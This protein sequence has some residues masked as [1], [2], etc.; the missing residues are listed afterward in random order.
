MSN[1]VCDLDLSRLVWPIDN[2]QEHTASGSSIDLT[3]ANTRCSGHPTGHSFLD[4]VFDRLF[5]ETSKNDVLASSKVL[6]SSSHLRPESTEP[7]SHRHE[8]QASS[9]SRRP[10][11]S[12]LTCQPKA[13]IPSSWSTSYILIR[14]NRESQF[15]SENPEL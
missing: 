14:I 2:D 8:S 11:N 12:F 10:F 5:G 13:L 15:P 4:S 7:V 9:S 6:A 3:W 1:V